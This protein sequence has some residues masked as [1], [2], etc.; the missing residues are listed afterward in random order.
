MLGQERFEVS[1]YVPYFQQRSLS[2]QPRRE[3]SMH[4]AKIGL[5]C[6]EMCNLISGCQ[7]NT[8]SPIC[9]SPSPLRRTISVFMIPLLPA[10]HDRGTGFAE[11]RLFPIVVGC[12]GAA[13]RLINQALFA[14]RRDD[15]RLYPFRRR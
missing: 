8:V 1:P 11:H 12:G 13:D 7:Y 15:P 4:R 3:R 10:N 14:V 6:L 5:P 9:S 2:P